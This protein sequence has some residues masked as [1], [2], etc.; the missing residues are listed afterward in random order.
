MNLSADV[1]VETV[2]KVYETAWKSGCK[3][4][5]VYRDGCRS[6]V[7]V[8]NEPKPKTTEQILKEN[9]AA[10][11]G[12]SLTCDVHRFNN[13]K[14]KWICFVGMKDGVPYEIFTGLAEEFEIPGYVET[15]SILKVK[16]EDKTNRYDFEYTDKGGFKTTKRGLSRSFNKEFW[17]Y[18]KLISGILRHRM[19][20]PS[21]VNTVSSM[22]FDND[23][24]SSW[25]SGIVRTLKKYV[26][27][28]EGGGV[29][30]KCGQNT[31]VYQSGCVICQSCGD[32]KCS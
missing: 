5:T 7:L 24:I 11:R 6:G 13:N 27:D 9:H 29:C 8:S 17:N 23:T 3:G 19:P 31:L 26:K 18:A 22:E 15:G 16:D 10:K 12:H 25:K 1:D 4:V 20:M 32:S 30:P 14:E 28:G 2:A 21:V